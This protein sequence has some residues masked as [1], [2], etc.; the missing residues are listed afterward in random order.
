MEREQGAT[1]PSSNHVLIPERI[2]ILGV[3]C[4]HV[5]EV[6]QHTNNAAKRTRPKNRN[7]VSAPNVP[8]TPER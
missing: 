2:M 7:P 4:H 8:K 1:W 3:T 5:T 6:P